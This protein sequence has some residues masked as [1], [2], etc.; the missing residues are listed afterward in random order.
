M[1]RIPTQIAGEKLRSLALRLKE[2]AWLRGNHRGYR[3][4]RDVD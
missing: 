1:G 3:A 2:S 4:P